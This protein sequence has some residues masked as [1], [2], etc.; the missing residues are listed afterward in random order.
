[1]DVIISTDLPPTHDEVNAAYAWPGWPQ[2]EAWRL[3]AVARSCTWLTAR[4]PDG[5]VVGLCR[6][7]DDGGLH[8]SL[9]DLLV[10]PD[11]RR[12]GIGTRLVEHA[13]G[14]V[15]DRSLLVLVATPES[16]A[17]FRRLGLVAELHGHTALYT[18]PMTRT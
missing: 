8:A 11:H 10:H 9:W 2:R 7:L 5:T 4:L 6:V 3:D 12:Q 16:A 14:L 1:V 17:L 13:L 15:R 18:R